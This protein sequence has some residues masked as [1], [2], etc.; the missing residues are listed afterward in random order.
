[1]L[2][3]LLAIR[4]KIGAMTFTDPDPG[5]EAAPSAAEERSWLHS[6]AFWAVLGGLSSLLTGLTTIGAVVVGI[7]QLRE[8]REL[9]LQNAAYASWNELNQADLANPELACP[10][11]EAKLQKLL[12]TVD[13]KS[14]TGGTYQDRYAAYGNLMITTSEQVLQMAPQDPYWRFRIAER[15]RCN[16]PASRFLRRQGTYEKRYS[17]RFR[18]VI[19][20]ALSEPPPKCDAA[21]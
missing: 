20:D 18:R 17:C 12:S 19:A 5:S 6:T 9:S 1:L 14:S 21:S 10:D 3:R 2:F 13:P 16:A 15:V 11:T 8:S 4:T 7:Q